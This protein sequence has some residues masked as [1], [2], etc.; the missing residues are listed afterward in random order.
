[1]TICLD[2]FRRL[3][4]SPKGPLQT[5]CID[6]SGVSGYISKFSDTLYYCLD[7]K[8]TDGSETTTN[9]GQFGNLFEAYDYDSYEKYKS[10][11]DLINATSINISEILRSF[12]F[13]KHIIERQIGGLSYSEEL[14]N[15]LWKSDLHHEYGFCYTF[16][17]SRMENMEKVKVITKTDTK[18][19]GS[20]FQTYLLFDVSPSSSNF[21]I[22]ASNQH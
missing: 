1:M 5:K 4:Q 15:P 10:L 11:E 3:Y 17:H 9:G 7:D 6:S 20:L 14:L 22:L 13:G 21:L 19:T 18:V 12:R 2:T 16:D 8:V